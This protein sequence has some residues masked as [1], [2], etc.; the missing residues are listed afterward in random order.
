MNL[1]EVEIVLLYAN[2]MHYLA[3]G[4]GCNYVLWV[5]TTV[6]EGHN[7]GVQV[8]NYSLVKCQ[9]CRS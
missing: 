5:T 2:G 6:W 1:K 8:I 9:M 4:K 7:Q 3:A